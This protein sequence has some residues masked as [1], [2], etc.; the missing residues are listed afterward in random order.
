M[1]AYDFRCTKC[2]QVFEVVR[3]MRS[4]AD[5]CCP[6]CGAAAKRVFTPVGVAFKGT[7]FHNT[8]YRPQPSESSKSPSPSE[9]TP[10][11]AKSDS[12]PACSSCPAAE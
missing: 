6:G 5:E 11:A 7:G 4:T 1:P 9:S 12:S 10:C 8:D 2:N 3:S